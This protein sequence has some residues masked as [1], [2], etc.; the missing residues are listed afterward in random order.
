MALVILNVAY[1]FA[2]VGVDAAD[3]AER[4]IAHLDSALVRAGH[5]SVVMACE[6]SVT[7]G[8][9][10]ATQLPSNGPG[11]A[12]RHRVYD[13]FRF[14]LRRFLE[15]WPIDLIHM[16]GVDF[17]EYLPAPSVPVLITLHSPLHLYPEKVFHLER[18]RTFMNF[19]LPGLRQSC[20][21]CDNLLPELETDVAIKPES[22]DRQSATV[23]YLALYERL[24]TE[25]RSTETHAFA[26]KE[27]SLVG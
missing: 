18:P 20:P 10:L 24:V 19:T 3:D 8:I 23:Q 6:G 16:H 9:L 17:Y 21:A 14:T 11:D 7:E 12:E 27:V 15:N 1:P 5:E 25:F 13:Q 26:A 4:I 2:R 22:G